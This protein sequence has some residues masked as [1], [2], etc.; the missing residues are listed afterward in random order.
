[1]T[2]FYSPVHFGLIFEVDAQTQRVGSAPVWAGDSVG[3]FTE[4]MPATGPVFGIQS[5]RQGPSDVVLFGPDTFTVPF[6]VSAT[7]SALLAALHPRKDL[8]GPQRIQRTV[9]ALRALRA[10]GGLVALAVRNHGL[11]SPLVILDVQVQDSST[12][13]EATIQVTFRRVRVVRLG[14]VQPVADE[15]TAALSQVIV[16]GVLP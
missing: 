6:K 3:D 5:G 4:A 11:E 2:A 10:K 15:E 14:L 16:F 7:T 9:A 8:I 1:M 12:L 13:L